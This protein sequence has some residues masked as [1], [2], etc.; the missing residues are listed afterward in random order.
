MEGS[1]PTFFRRQTWQGRFLKLAVAWTA[2]RGRRLSGDPRLCAL[3][4]RCLWAEGDLERGMRYLV[5]G[6]RP[7]E[8][9]DL[10]MQDV[11][12]GK[13][14]CGEECLASEK[15]CRCVVTMLSITRTQR[16]VRDYLSTVTISVKQAARRRSSN[17]NSR[18]AFLTAN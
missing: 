13:S 3:L 15:R 2:A 4:G 18:S 8:L 9:C 1:R 10:I 12:S 11:P 16:H 14:R 5:L 6:E 7:Q 17:I